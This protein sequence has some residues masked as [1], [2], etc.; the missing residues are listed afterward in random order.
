M[1]GR[2]GVTVEAVLEEVANTLQTA[3]DVSV[4]G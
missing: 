1:T 4:S 2:D 3:L